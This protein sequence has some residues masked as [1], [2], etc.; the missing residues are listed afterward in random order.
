MPQQEGVDQMPQQQGP[1]L[2]PE[3][4]TQ[5]QHEWLRFEPESATA[6]RCRRILRMSVPTP[7]CIDWGLL[8][9]AG[10]A[11]RAR[12]ILGEDT[13]WTRLFDLADL[14]TYRLITVEFLSTFRYI[15]HQPAVREEEDEELPDI[16]FS[17]GGQHH[18]M[19]IERFAVQL[20][21]YY[22]S[23]TVR[24]DFIQGL[25]QGE[26]GLSWRLIAKI[27]SSISDLETCVPPDAWEQDV[28]RK[29]S[30][31]LGSNPGVKP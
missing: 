29:P 12:A 1:P 7:R 19:S 13:S 9:D 18:A 31:P 6:M 11:V 15:A 24:E 8:A 28:I 27:D 5:S 20:G 22:E 30:P 10:E 17:L 16:E 26:E 21:L 23:E 3:S 14:L 25:T 2:D 4:L